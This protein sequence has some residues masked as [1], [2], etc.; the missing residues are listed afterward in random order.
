M[1]HPDLDLSIFQQQHYQE[2]ATIDE[3][4]RSPSGNYLPPDAASLMYASGAAGRY[5]SMCH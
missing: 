3:A 4:K 1:K 5:V 2:F